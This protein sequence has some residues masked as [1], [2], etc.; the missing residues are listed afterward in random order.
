M[1]SNQLSFQLAPASGIFTSQ[2]N[3]AVSPHLTDLPFSCRAF[4]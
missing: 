3:K 2:A 1:A 4:F